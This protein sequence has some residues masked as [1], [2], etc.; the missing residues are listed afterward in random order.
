MATVLPAQTAL[1]AKLNRSRPT[2]KERK[3]VRQQQQYQTAPPT[4]IAGDALPAATQAEAE[5]ERAAGAA[6]EVPSDALE[7]L[8]LTEQA[9]HTCPLVFTPDAA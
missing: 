8:A 2:Q 7:W 1:N 4:A 5:L 6:A 9:P 3:L